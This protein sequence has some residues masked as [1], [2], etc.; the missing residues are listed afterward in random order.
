M[1]SSST[2]LRQGYAGHAGNREL[3]TENCRLNHQGTKS[4]K[5]GVTT[6]TASNRQGAK[7][8]KNNGPSFSPAGNREPAFA[9]RATAGRLGTGNCRSCPPT[10]GNCLA[11]APEKSGPCFPLFPP[12]PYRVPLQQGGAHFSAQVLAA[13]GDAIADFFRTPPGAH[14]P[15]HKDAQGNFTAC[16]GTN[17][18]EINA[19][20]VISP[21]TGNR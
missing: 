20:T 19:L 11:K 7:D 4:T 17:F 9:P 15:D 21:T 1:L 16:P 5:L 18:G 3:G 10:T 2:R 13:Q 14:I 8:A 12:P 6:T